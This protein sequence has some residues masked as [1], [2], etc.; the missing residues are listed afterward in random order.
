MVL[1][2]LGQ[3]KKGY[4]SQQEFFGQFKEYDLYIPEIRHRGGYDSC[5]AVVANCFS[6]HE[7]SQ[8]KAVHVLSYILGT[9]VLNRYINKNGPGN[10]KTIIYD[11]SPIQER[12]AKV[13]VK[14]IPNMAKIK[15]GHIAHDIA[16]I[17]YE[18]IKQ[19]GIRIGIIVESKASKLM[20]TFKRTGKSFGPI[21]WKNFDYKQQPEDL[22]FTRLDHDE[23]YVTFD[24][25]GEDIIHFI[26]HGKFTESARRE[27]YTWDHWKKYKK[28]RD[29]PY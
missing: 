28:R 7:L 29:G 2:G 11:R 15:T 20:R 16:K 6:K 25:I 1:T 21:D 3:S 17:S 14:R 26:R 5:Y 4:K 13:V 18:P 9:K 23:M 22:I 10:I 24:E 8:Y 12:A 19:D 27:P